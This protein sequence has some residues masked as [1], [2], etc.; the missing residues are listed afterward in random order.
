[1]T[2]DFKI[3]I[4]WIAFGTVALTVTII[5][6]I[7][8]LRLTASIGFIMLGLSYLSREPKILPASGIESGEPTK[9]RKIVGRILEISALVIFVVLLVTQFSKFFEDIIFN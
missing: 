5:K 2:N 9:S 6:N 3:G 1:M 4:A 7:E 8:T